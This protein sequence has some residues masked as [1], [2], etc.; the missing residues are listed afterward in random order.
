[1]FK[2]DAKVQPR[3]EKRTRLKLET[4]STT[5]LDLKKGGE[6]SGELRYLLFSFP[7]CPVVCSGSPGSLTPGFLRCVA[8]NPD[9]SDI[10]LNSEK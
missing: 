5:T 4:L 10:E 6:N 7:L 2:G 3:L 8:Q 1:M 9:S